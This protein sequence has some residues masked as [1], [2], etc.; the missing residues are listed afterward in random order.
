MRRGSSR[1]RPK[2]EEATTE[3]VVVVTLKSLQGYDIADYGYQLGRHWG[4]GQAD[5]NNGLLFIIAPRNARPASTWATAWR[6]G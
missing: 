4:I 3:Q 6:A 5:K 2:H 1:R